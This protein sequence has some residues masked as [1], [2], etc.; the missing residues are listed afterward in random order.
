M[1]LFRALKPSTLNSIALQYVRDRMGNRYQL[2]AN[3][4]LQ[5]CVISP[6]IPLVVY[7]LNDD[8]LPLLLTPTSMVLN[9]EVL[10]DRDMVDAISKSQ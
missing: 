2:T 8:P 6:H 10:S 9:Q 4:R 1:I 7:A 3:I 5:D